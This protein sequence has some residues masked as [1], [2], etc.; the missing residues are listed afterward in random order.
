MS[1]VIEHLQDPFDFIKSVQNISRPGTIFIVETPCPSGLDYFLFKQKYWGGY[2]FPRH[3]N[4]F[5]K[6]NLMRLFERPGFL[7]LKHYFLPSAGWII[8]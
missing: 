2:H 1:Q 3:T 8:L 7:V 5:N 4:L 6:N